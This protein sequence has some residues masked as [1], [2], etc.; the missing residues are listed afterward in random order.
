MPI[1]PSQSPRGTSLKVLFIDLVSQRYSVYR[2][3]RLRRA[4]DHISSEAQT[5]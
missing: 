2:D 4:V 3:V 5:G 1:M